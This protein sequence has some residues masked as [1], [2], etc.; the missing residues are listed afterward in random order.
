VKYFSLGIFALFLLSS[1]SDDV[2]TDKTDIEAESLYRYFPLDSGSY[3]IYRVD[4]IIHN[5]ADD[6]TN[7]PDSLIDT[8]QYE[9]KEVVDS[10]FID[11]EGDLAWRISRYYRDI[12]A[13]DWSFTTLWTAKRTLQSAQKVEENIR[14]VKLSFPV[15]LNK[16]WNGNLFNFLQ[17]EDYS[18]EEANTPLSIGGYNFDSSVTVLELQDANLIHNIFKEEK[19]VYGLGLVYRQRDSLNINGL[20]IITNGVEFHQSLIDYSPR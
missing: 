8:F 6:N 3:I 11:G 15:R 12:G 20:G 19:Y 1:C 13:S 18:I 7:N 2:E 10:D 4:S 16:T 5:Y 14:Y 9:V 17:E